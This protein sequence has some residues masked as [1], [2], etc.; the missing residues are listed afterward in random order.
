MRIN[1]VLV[2][3]CPSQEVLTQPV[4]NM[5]HPIKRDMDGENKVGKTRCLLFISTT[6]LITN[7]LVF[8]NLSKGV[9][10]A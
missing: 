2:T 9:S 3:D 1:K 7:V 6:I 10:D 8:L 5:E 4:P